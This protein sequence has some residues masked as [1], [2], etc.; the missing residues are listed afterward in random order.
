MAITLAELLWVA[1]TLGYGALGLSIALSIRTDD[2]GL[3]RVSGLLFFMIGLLAVMLGQP[4]WFAGL[5]A[6]GALACFL[7]ARLRAKRE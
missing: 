7:R 4:Y 6:A 1:Q 5:L 3:W 2:K